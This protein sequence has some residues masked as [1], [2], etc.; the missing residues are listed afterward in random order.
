MCTNNNNNNNKK[1][2][3]TDTYLRDLKEKYVRD[4]HEGCP[5]SDTRRTIKTGSS[6]SIYLQHSHFFEVVSSAL[7]TQFQ[8]SAPRFKGILIV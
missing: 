8:S 5:V 6:G 2:N 4:V 1:L 7:H 3:M